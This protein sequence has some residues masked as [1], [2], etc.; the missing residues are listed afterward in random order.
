MHVCLGINAQGISDMELIDALNRATALQNDGKWNEALNVFLFIGENTSLQRNEVEREVYVFTQMMACQC[1]GLIGKY[2]EGYNLAKKLLNGKLT[3]KETKRIRNSLVSNGYMYAYQ[4]LHNDKEDLKKAVYLFEELLPFIDDETKIKVKNKIAYAWYNQG[5]KAQIRQ[6]YDVALPYMRRAEEGYKQ[7]EDTKN[8]I[9]AICNIASIYYYLHEFENALSE[10]RNAKLLA[11]NLKDNERIMSILIEEKRVNDKLGNTE[12]SGIILQT[13]DSLAHA[14]SSLNTQ[15]L[16][17]NFKGDEAR[18]NGYLELSELWHKRN[19]AFIPQMEGKIT[20]YRHAHY[21]DLRDLYAEMKRYEEALHYGRLCIEEVR[22]TSNASVLECY[23]SYT[24]IA[25]IYKL[26]DDKEGCETAL[27]TLFLA[28]RHLVEPREKQ[29]IYFTRASCYQ[30]FGEYE[31][32]LADYQTLDAILASKYS[33]TDGDRIV[34]LPLMGGLEHQLG[35][36]EESKR[37]YALYVKRIKDKYGKDC[38]E[39]INALFYLAN[40]EAF[41]GNIET[42]CNCYIEAVRMAKG[43]LKERLPYLTIAEREG[44]WQKIYSMF[45][46]MAPF[47]IEAGQNQTDFTVSCYDALILTKTFLLES[48]KSAYDVVKKNGN[49]SALDDF[50]EMYSLQRKLKDW[51]KDSKRYA[52]SITAAN[53]KINILSRKLSDT[54]RELGDVTSFMDIDYKVVKSALGKESVLI[55]FTDYISKSEGRKYAAFIVNKKQNKP[56]L[57]PLFTE[58]NIDSLHILSPDYYYEEPYATDIRKLLWEPLSVHVKEGSTVYYVPS[59]MLFQIALESIPLEDGTLLGEHYN[60]VRLSSARELVRY[61]SALDIAN[62]NAKAILYGGLTYDIEPDDI[63]AAAMKYEIPPMFALRGGMMRGDSIYRELPGT[64]KEVLAVGGILRQN[65]IK[66]ESRMGVEGT[67][68]SFVGMNGKA[69]DYL[70]MATH[71]FYYTPQEAE[72]F[73]YLKGYKDAMSL[74]GLVFSGGNAAWLGKSIPEGVMGGILTASDIA[75][76][77]LS[78][79]DMVVLSACQ[80]GQGKATSEG[81]YGL[82]RAFKKAGVNTIVMTLW[83]VDDEVTREFMVKFH[84]FL[85]KPTNKW[86]KRKAFEQAKAYIRQQRPESSYWAGFVML[87]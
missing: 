23:L 30:A 60:F 42:A 39:Y 72:N 1:Y 17:N 84:E 18:A 75:T 49:D 68:E 38:D 9:S 45:T 86:N 71:G 16:Y 73:E 80:T 55:D 47:A 25:Q 6:Q 7:S 87:D 57:M 15:F 37:L 33:E 64:E 5:I 77:D 34:L 14:D 44:Y 40:A 66:V 27:D 26:M 3:A 20:G 36:Y 81:L 51:E 35:N 41:A 29:Q 48:D 74:S 70:L 69:P 63:Q 11:Q 85:A 62:K 2:E 19:D 53:A 76:L 67:A 21:N 4:C 83:N 24:A 54:T 58:N 28:E 61:K 65:G 50:T 78:G 46:N 43:K 52:D 59:H 31:K 8:V 32:A 56:L 82:Q 22:S 10:Y 13:I 79:M 12:K